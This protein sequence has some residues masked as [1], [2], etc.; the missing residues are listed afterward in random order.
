MGPLG[1]QGDVIQI[2]VIVGILVLVG[3]VVRYIGP[4]IARRL[5]GDIDG[6]RR[7][8]LLHADVDELKARLAELEH[9]RDRL[10]ELEERLDFTERMLAKPADAARMER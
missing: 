8:D 9:D 3:R 10:S 5:G 4:A 2:I 6:G 7:A 1:S